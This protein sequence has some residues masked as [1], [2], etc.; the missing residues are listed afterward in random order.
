MP[1]E[2]ADLA[3]GLSGGI[4]TVVEYFLWS[5]PTHVDGDDSGILDDNGLVDTTN[6]TPTLNRSLF[7]Y[8]IEEMPPNTRVAVNEAASGTDQFGQF[9][10]QFWYTTKPLH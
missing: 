3:G 4:E 2:L 1:L 10:Q 5:L 7:N 6:N 9:S 8:G